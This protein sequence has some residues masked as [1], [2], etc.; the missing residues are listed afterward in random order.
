MKWKYISTQ[1]HCLRDKPLLQKERRT[2]SPT[3]TMKRPTSRCVCSRIW[4]CAS[5]KN[6]RFRNQWLPMKNQT[7]LTLHRVKLFLCDGWRC[8]A[9]SIVLVKRIQVQENCKKLCPVCMNALWEVVHSF[10]WIRI[11]INKISSAKTETQKFSEMSRCWREGRHNCPVHSNKN[12]F[13]HEQQRSIDQDAVTIFKRWWKQGY[14]L[15]RWC[16]FHYLPYCTEFGYHREKGSC[17]NCRLHGYFCHAYH[18]WKSEMKNIFF[19]QKMLR[20]WNIT[21]LFPRLGKVKDHI[22]F[23][24]TMT[25]CDTTEVPYGKRKKSFLNQILKSKMLQSFSM[26]MQDIWSEWDWRGCSQMLC[27]D[28]HSLEKWWNSNFSSVGTSLFL[29]IIQYLLSIYR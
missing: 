20:G 21:S 16:R 10:W 18:H 11:S 6:H 14:Q 4:S 29:K 9:A 13:Q 28:V 24:H 2:K 19:Q 22:L 27:R 12:F 17:F 3:F 23:V 15:F 26:T 8:F 5:Q 1:Q 25:G 7:N